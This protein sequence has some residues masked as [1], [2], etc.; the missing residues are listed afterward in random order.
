[1]TK[2]KEFFSAYSLIVFLNSPI[3]GFI[4]FLL[5]FINPNAAISAII[6]AA[7]T[8]LFLKVIRNNEENGRFLAKVLCRNSLLLGFLIGNLFALNWQIFLFLIAINFFNFIISSALEVS[9]EKQSLPILSLP[10]CLSALIIFILLPQLYAL[11]ILPKSYFNLNLSTFLP[12][13]ALHFFHSI[14]SIFLFTNPLLGLLFWLGIFVFSPICASFLLIGFLLG[15]GFESTLHSINNNPNFYSD[16]LNYS[17]IFTAIGA[18]FLIPSR[19]SI[20]LATFVTLAAVPL[21]ITMARIMNYWSL[22][23]LS[24]PFCFISLLTLTLLRNLRPSC[25]SCNFFNSPEQNF[26]ISEMLKKRHK[27]GEIGIFLPVKNLWKIEQGFNGKITHRGQWKYGLDFVAV[28]EKGEKFCNR[29]FEIGDHFTFGQE[30]FSPIEGWVFDCFDGNLDNEI[31]QVSSEQYGNYLILHSV[32][33]YFVALLHLKKDSLLVKKGDFVKVG[34]QLAKCGNSGYSQ[35]PHLH[36]NV[37]KT[38]KLGEA[39]M[40][41]HLLNYSANS[42]INFHR[43]PQENEIIAPL[44][45]NQISRKIF[46]FHIGQKWLFKD[47]NNKIFSLENQMDEV[48][49][50]FYLTDGKYRV[51]HSKNGE[52]FYFYNLQAPKNSILSYLFI[53]ASRFA[54]TYGE[55]FFYNDHLPDFLTKK[56]SS[57]SLNFLAKILQLKGSNKFSSNYLLKSSGFY[58]EGTHKICARKIS[59]F[60]KID[61]AIG[62]E[63]FGVGKEKFTRHF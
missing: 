45:I 14:S 50:E 55:E 42:E 25:L 34:Q 19:F 57:N 31:G 20:L 9:F 48:L 1:M 22:P 59:S 61:P 30:I 52:S 4:F 8:N 24:L 33:G 46:N 27:F 13:F 2:L 51:Y 32:Y 6:S 56:I 16:S 60:F 53:A 15:N 62:I 54:F 44:N 39:N 7:I 38:A 26:A 58:L 18:I 40:P 49:G 43:S 21:V 36:L 17:L 12:D 3:L 5:S 35:E 23:T 37:Q 63:S 41:F 47:A 10:F 28:N 29:G 11:T